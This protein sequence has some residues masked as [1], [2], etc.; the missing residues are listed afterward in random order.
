MHDADVA[1][2][3]TPGKIWRLCDKISKATGGCGAW[4]K[5]I[6]KSKRKKNR[7]AYDIGSDGTIATGPWEC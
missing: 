5:Y 4:K 7:R 6:H 1:C 3:E 2:M